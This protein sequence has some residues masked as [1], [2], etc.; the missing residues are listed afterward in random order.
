MPIRV[1]IVSLAHLHAVGYAHA[2]AHD[3]GAEFTG[4]WD[5]Q[6]GRAETHAKNWNVPLSTDFDQFLTTVDAVIITCEN[7]RHAELGTA[8]ARAGK[9]ILCEKPLVTSADEASLL[10]DAVESAGVILMTAFP[11]RFSPSY[12]RLKERVRAG[13]V[14][15]V[16]AICSTNRGRCPFDW[17]VDSA[18]SGGG[19]MIDHT[20]HVADL[21]RDLLGCEPTRV[22]AQVGNNMYSQSWEDTAMLTIEFENGAF[23]TLDSSWSRPASFKT[24][25]DVTMNVVG[26]G[27]VI[28]MDMFGQEL[29]KY[30][31]ASPSHRTLGWGSSLD[32][33]MVRE[34][35]EAIEQNRSPA[36]TGLDGWQAARVALAGY[37]S[38]QTGRPVSL[39]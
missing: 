3:T 12:R 29:Q 27:G 22:F 35:L 18:L 39:A 9:H 28:E 20:V 16:R 6:P 7:R 17:F 10:M 24:W 13:D 34:F 31:E 30:G 36:A 26:E 1:G 23:A 33:L 4:V 11:C 38:L 25:G 5:D 15:T 2:L 21:L 14:G 8:A 37:E 32:S 19:A